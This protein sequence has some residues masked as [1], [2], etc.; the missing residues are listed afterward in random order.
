M[1]FMP[2]YCSLVRGI[3]TEM[4]TVETV[5]E[6]DQMDAAGKPIFRRTAYQRGPFKW[7]ASA[8]KALHEAAEL[9]MVH[10]IAIAQ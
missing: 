3:T 5:H 6:T 2:V 8:L 10:V 4:E 1:Y 9:Y 7:R